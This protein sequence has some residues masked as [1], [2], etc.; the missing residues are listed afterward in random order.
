[1]T[2]AGQCEGREAGWLYATMAKY[3]W[4]AQLMV[5]KVGRR[6]EWTGSVDHRQLTVTFG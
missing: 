2:M 3:V 6:D 5:E 4:E 1:M